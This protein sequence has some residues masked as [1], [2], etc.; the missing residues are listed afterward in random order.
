MF[1]ESVKCVQ[2]MIIFDQNPAYHTEEIN[3]AVKVDNR[4]SKA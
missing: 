3:E 1:F 2:I 4:K